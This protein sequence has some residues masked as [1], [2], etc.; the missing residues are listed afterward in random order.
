V[1]KTL[2]C[3]CAAFT[4]TCQKS[5]YTHARAWDFCEYLFNEATI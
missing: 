5:T 4:R 3:T 2:M 1:S